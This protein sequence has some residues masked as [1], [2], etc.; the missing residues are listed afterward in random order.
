MTIEELSA[1]VDELY[2]LVDSRVDAI[3]AEQTRLKE[4]VSEAVQAQKRVEALRGDV[5]FLK[6]ANR[7]LDAL[8]DSM[9]RVLGQLRKDQPAE[10][11]DS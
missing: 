10:Q 11:A 9:T 8:R 7:S 2:T 1:K 4:S 5:D 6:A 3:A